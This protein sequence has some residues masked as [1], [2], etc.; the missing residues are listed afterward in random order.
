MGNLFQRLARFRRIFL[1]NQP[2]QD[3]KRVVGCFDFQQPG[4][5]HRLR[6]IVRALLDSLHPYQTDVAERVLAFA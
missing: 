6:F 5:L 4:I 1:G 3:C 2:V